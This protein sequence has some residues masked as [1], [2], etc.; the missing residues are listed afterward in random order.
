MPTDRQACY[1]ALVALAPRA[2]LIPEALETMTPY[3][4]QAEADRFELAPADA[5]DLREAASAIAR[6][7]GLPA[8]RVLTVSLAEPMP[9]PAWMA[10]QEY[11][12]VVMDTLVSSHVDRISR[13]ID[14]LVD[15][16]FVRLGRNGIPFRRAFLDHL[17]NALWTSLE[18]CVSDSLKIPLALPHGMRLWQVLFLYLGSAATADEETMRRFAPL[19]TLFSRA[20]PL[21][22][23]RDERGAWLVLAA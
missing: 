13:T 22:E 19:V 7:T 9:R 12:H 17:G 2:A 20:I 6:A 1:D 4:A 16:V 10:R 18:N 3:F 14:P 11:D 8:D 5:I 23:K 15:A 21:G